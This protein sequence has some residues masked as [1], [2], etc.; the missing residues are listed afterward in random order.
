MHPGQPR[1]RRHSP[2]TYRL[3][4]AIVASAAVVV[5]YLGYQTFAGGGDDTA[6]PPATTT[7]TTAAAPAVPPCRDDVEA[8]VAEDPKEAWST[9]IV[10]TERALPPSYGPGDLHNISEAGFPFTDGLALRGFVMTDLQA[11]REEAASNGTPIS[12][13]AAYRSYPTQVDLFERRVDELGASEAGSRVARPGHSE[14]QLGTTIDVTS[15]GLTDVDQSWGA[16]PTGQWV[17]SNAHKYGFILSYPADAQTATCYDYEPWHLRY[18]GR[19]QAAQV[20]ASGL[21]LRE[22]LF[23]LGLHAPVTPTPT[24]TSTTAAG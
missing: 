16:S 17:R 10:D 14:H 8:I 24:S 23:S 18:V 9:I 12:I 6:A 4:R 15:E 5:L 2:Q 22:Y 11:M 13:I 7:T 20:I 1:I 3:R 19:D 21:T